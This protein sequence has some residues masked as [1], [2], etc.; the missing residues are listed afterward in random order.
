MQAAERACVGDGVSGFTG[1]SPADEAYLCMDLTFQH[2]LLTEGFGLGPSASL[3]LVK[4]VQ[5]QGNAI[6]AAWPL[7]AAINSLG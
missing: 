7:G 2:T 1:V 5:Y 4:Q 3:T 6:E